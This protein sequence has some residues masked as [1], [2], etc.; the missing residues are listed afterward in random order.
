MRCRSPLIL[1]A[2]ALVAGL[3]VSAAAPAATSE[4]FDV[5]NVSVDATAQ[6]A[7][8]A[9]DMAMAQGRQRAWAILSNRFLDA[10]LTETAPQL[11][12]DGLL[13][14]IGNVEVRDEKRGRT[15]CGWCCLLE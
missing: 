4:S 15:S 6:S 5:S 10:G 14:L 7:S 12:D 9:R 3:S 8:A 11:S 2:L 13:H 1:A